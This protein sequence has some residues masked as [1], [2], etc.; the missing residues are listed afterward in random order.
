MISLEEIDQVVHQE[1]LE[2]TWASYYQVCPD[3]YWAKFGI[4]THCTCCSEMVFAKYA[5]KGI[6]AMTIIE[7]ILSSVSF[8]YTILLYLRRS[9]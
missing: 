2:T 3:W 5:S 7:S 6:L 4:F 8:G 1:V 9:I